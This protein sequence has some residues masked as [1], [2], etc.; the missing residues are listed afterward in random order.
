MFYF[1][2]WGGDC[3]CVC[4]EVGKH[5]TLCLKKRGGLLGTGNV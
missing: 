5:F 3:V 4:V 2:G 1:E